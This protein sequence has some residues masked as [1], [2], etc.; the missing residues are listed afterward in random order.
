MFLIANLGL[1]VVRRGSE[2]KTSLGIPID[3]TSVLGVG[4]PGLL[5]GPE[6]RSGILNINWGQN[7]KF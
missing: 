6:G 1:G 4:W 3:G 2:L 5:V 7:S